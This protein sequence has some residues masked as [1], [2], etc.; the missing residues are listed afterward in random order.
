MA[1]LGKMKENIA[2]HQDNGLTRHAHRIHKIQQRSEQ[3]NQAEL[4][5]LKNQRQGLKKCQR[6]RLARLQ[7]SI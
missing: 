2:L 4:D 5:K 6:N 3:H 1:K 7:V